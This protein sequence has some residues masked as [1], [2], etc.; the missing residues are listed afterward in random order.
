MKRKYGFVAGF[1]L[2]LALCSYGLTAF[3]V[4]Q[5]EEKITEK[6]S[7]V[8]SFYPM[9]IAAENIIGDCD[10]V[11]LENLSEPQTGCMHD[12]QLTPSDMKLLSHADVFIVNGGRIETFLADVAKQFPDL[13]IINACENI[14][15]LADNAHAWM[16]I[17]DYRK[18]IAAITD[19]LSRADEADAGLFEENFR[20]Y[21]VSLVS[22]QEQQQ[23][24]RDAAAGTKIISFHEAYEYVAKDYGWKV[25]YTMDLDEER[26][27][28]A[29]E[30]ADVLAAVKEEGISVIL[31]EEL[32]GSDMGDTVKKESDAKVYYLNT[33]LRGDY[34]PDSYIRGMQENINILKEA[35]GVN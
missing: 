25:C 4:R 2:V 23:E 14:E 32:Y 19:G 3:Y 24:I 18:Q 11:T 10:N 13:T 21:D 20:T 29:G 31:A 33:I 8:T 7:V 17:A 34:A 1:L 28:S 15:L 27:V 5:Q 16:S 30:V 9:Y 12:Y 35:F 22:L 6:L 26:Q